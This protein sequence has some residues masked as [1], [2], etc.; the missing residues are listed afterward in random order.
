[1]W[2][3]SKDTCKSTT[4]WPLKVLNYKMEEGQKLRKNLHEVISNNTTIL[5]LFFFLPSKKK[6]SVSTSTSPTVLI[7]IVSV[8]LIWIPHSDKIPPLTSRYSRRPQL[9]RLSFPLLSS[10]S[11]LMPLDLWCITLLALL[12]YPNF[13]LL[14]LSFHLAVSQGGELWAI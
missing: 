1:M 10:S 14:L 4:D 7:G 13:L 12:V 3:S 2:Q 5:M 9:D 11:H 6:C 8:S